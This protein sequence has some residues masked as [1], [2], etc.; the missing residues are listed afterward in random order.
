MYSVL[1]A[2]VLLA[3]TAP[4]EA[5]WAGQITVIACVLELSW[6]FETFVLARTTTYRYEAKTHRSH[7]IGAHFGLKTLGKY[8]DL[9]WFKKALWVI[10]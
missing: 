1:L 4:L 6:N 2:R 7:V 10:L 3:R 5:A 8:L 9:R